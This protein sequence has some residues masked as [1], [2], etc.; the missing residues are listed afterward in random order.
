[1]PSSAPT[2]DRALFSPLTWLAIG[3]LVCA[4]TTEELLGYQVFSWGNEALSSYLLLLASQ[5]VFA[6]VL[7]ALGPRIKSLLQRK[8]LLIALM[9]IALL[10]AAIA[11][12][13]GAEGAAA[14][15]ALGFVLLSLASFLLKIINLEILAEL[16]P[17]TLGLVVFAAVLGQSVCAPIFALSSTLS[18]MLAGISAVVGVGCAAGAQGLLRRQAEQGSSP[19]A[20]SFQ[21]PFSPS[22]SILVGVGI[23]C[24][25]VSFLNPLAF[26]PSISPTAFVSFTF[27]THFAAALLFGLV[28]LFG[29]GTSYATAFRSVDT[30]VLVGFFLMALLGVSALAPR[31]VC[32]IAFSLFEFVTF[33]ALADLASYS[34]TNHLR[35][36]GGYYLL[37]RLCSLLGIALN[38]DDVIL[39]SFGL[40]ISLFGSLLAVACVIASI[41]LLTEPHLNRFF[42]GN[43]ADEIGRASQGRWTSPQE[44]NNALNPTESDGTLASEPQGSSR[45]LEELIAESVT[46]LAEDHGLTPREREVFGLMAQGR[47]STFISEE[48][49]VSTNTVRKHIAHVY[50]KLGVHSKQELLTLVQQ[51]SSKNS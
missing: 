15:F 30:L 35:L 24:V 49:F 8:T 4:I 40:P 17:R 45:A 18:W 26:Y 34:R 5:A 32:T 39:A 2:R 19:G 21:R 16:P 28:V 36:F 51:E 12:A 33:L 47:S 27:L 13:G 6:G 31:A 38:A 22:A 23:I 46:H 42:W 1:M 41:W 43:P 44:P 11:V 3:S 29:R 48:L 25:G 37:M 14:L 9:V 7:L 50:E 10:G 20:S